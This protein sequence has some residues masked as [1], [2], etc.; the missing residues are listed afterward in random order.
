MDRII[1][2]PHHT[3]KSSAEHETLELRKKSKLKILQYHFSCGK[4]TVKKL[5]KNRSQLNLETDIIGL[6]LRVRK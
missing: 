5:P 4:G 1:D 2:I 3:E 6:L